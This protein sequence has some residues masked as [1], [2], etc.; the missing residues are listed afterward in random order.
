MDRTI[1]AVKRSVMDRITALSSLAMS[2]A[3]APTLAAVLGAGLRSIR[4]QRGERQDDIAHLAR[5]HGL[6]WTRTTVAKVERG[7]RAMSVEEVVL[8]SLALRVAMSDLVSGA[9]MIA[10]TE[11]AALSAR[12]LRA[13]LD[14]RRDDVVLP[15][16]DIPAVRQAPAR[17][18]QLARLFQRTVAPVWP[19][20][21]MWAVKEAQMAASNDAEVN[22][23]RR[24]GVAP[25]LVALAAC[26]RWGRT[27]T[28]ERD[29]RVA[30]AAPGDASSRTLTA[31]RGHVTRQLVAELEAELPAKSTEGTAH[32]KG[33][34]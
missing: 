32:T 4:E 30:E 29:E 26:R 24:L 14:G 8:L 20:P 6:R 23:S 13:L 12:N 18:R 11:D 22:A 2:E 33:H 16:V 28:A 34:R 10:I 17:L 5:L 9:D 27:L 31:L 7:E 1:A 25:F 19:D 15:G 3:K 21:P